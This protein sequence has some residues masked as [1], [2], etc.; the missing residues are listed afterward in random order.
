MGVDQRLLHGT[1]AGLGAITQPVLRPAAESSRGISGL[2]L[3]HLVV[4]GR[5]SLG[6]WSSAA[7]VSVRPT[8][9]CVTDPLPANPKRST[10]LRRMSRGAWNFGGGLRDLMVSGS[11]HIGLG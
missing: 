5:T 3:R 9:A 8:T 2:Q 4:L 1:D 7:R 11:D 6:G 10:P